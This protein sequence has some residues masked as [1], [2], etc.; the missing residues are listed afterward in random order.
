[1]KKMNLKLLV[2]VGLVGL[3]SACNQDAEVNPE[4]DDASLS[5][6]TEIES[7]FDDI[8]NF[9]AEG[10]DGIVYNGNTGARTDGQWRRHLPDCAIVTHDYE[11]KT[12]TIDFGEAC[13]GKGGKIFSGIIFTTYTDRKFIPGSI[14]TTTFENFM[15]DG[16]L[17]EG[18]RVSENISEGLEDNPTFH[19]TLTNGKVTFDDGSFATK[20]ADK[21]KMWL[22]A[23]NPLNDEYHI[24]EGS[25]TNGV[26][27]E[28]VEYNSLIIE[29]LVYKN[30][31]RLDGIHVPV[32]GVKEVTIGDRFY[33][34]DFGD[35][36]CDNLATVTSNGETKTIEL[37]RRRRL[38]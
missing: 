30:I 33:S 26:N 5:L 38:N 2:V 25:K 32:A 17:I 27:I 16:K 14:V 10:I 4:F 6:E 8:D 22:R 11:A 24:L 23:T 7:D 18:T 21:T 9:V 34:I 37:K 13:E 15:V 3:F 31:C 1:M 36:E 35:G 20:E 28:G 19:I 29:T 12:I